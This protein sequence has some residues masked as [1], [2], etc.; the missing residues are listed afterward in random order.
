M[1][2]NPYIGSDVNEFFDSYRENRFRPFGKRFRRVF[3]GNSAPIDL[4]KEMLERITKCYAL[5]F[6]EC[7]PLL[8]K[9][10]E[11]YSHNPQ[12]TLAALVWFSPYHKEKYYIFKGKP[13]QYEERLKFK[14]KQQEKLKRDEQIRIQEEKYRADHCKYC[15]NKREHKFYDACRSCH[16]KLEHLRNKENEYYAIKSLLRKTTE[17]I[18]KCRNQ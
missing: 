17:R 12:R 6:P 1:I 13:F 16:T 11:R 3:Y 10:C 14:W 4:A 9:I 8:E 15:D 18:R 2:K 5:E 7:L